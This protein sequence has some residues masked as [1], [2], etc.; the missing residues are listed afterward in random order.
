MSEEPA[1]EPFCSS[2]GTPFSDDCGA[3]RGFALSAFLRVGDGVYRTYFTNGRGVD[4]LR[5]DL[6]MFYLTSV[7]RQEEWEDSPDGW[8]R[9][10]ATS[11]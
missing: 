10:E 3:G 6:N 2:R 7:G 4:R 9:T 5:L 1:L 8:P 11:P